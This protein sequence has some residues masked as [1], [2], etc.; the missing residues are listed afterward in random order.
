[1]Y[2]EIHSILLFLT[3]SSL[4]SIAK[5]S[6]FRLLQSIREDVLAEIIPPVCCCPLLS[7]P[8]IAGEDTENAEQMIVIS[9]M[10]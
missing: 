9:Y 10:I 4:K 7:L 3:P 6:I 8:D 2:R 1:V 5:I